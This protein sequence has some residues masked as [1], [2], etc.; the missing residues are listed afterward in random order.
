V[1]TSARVVGTQVRVHGRRV[2]GYGYNEFFSKKMVTSPS[3]TRTHVPVYPPI[4]RHEFI[5]TDCTRR[6]LA[7]LCPEINKLGSV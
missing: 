3:Q 1:G 7:N 2:N 4:P 5:G 6:V